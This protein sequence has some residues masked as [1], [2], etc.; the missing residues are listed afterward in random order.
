MSVRN[1]STLDRTVFQP[2]GRIIQE[3]FADGLIGTGTAVVTKTFADS[4]GSKRLLNYTATFT[5]T[6]DSL[7]GCYKFGATV[8]ADITKVI[9][10][11]GVDLHLT[12]NAGFQQTYAD[13]NCA[14]RLS[15]RSTGAPALAGQ[16]I[17]AIS[18]Q[19]QLDESTSAPQHLYPFSF[20]TDASKGQWD[21][22]FRAERDA[23]LALAAHHTDAF[24]HSIPIR[25]GIKNYYI[26][27][28]ET[29]T[30]RS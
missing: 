23:C 26:M 24:S 8:D 3:A 29:I 10:V 5:G 22:L 21:G 25:V 17:S 27:L 28:T 7:Y 16:G 11:M 20:N 2:L 30:N 19:L 6:N 1:L 14:L 13:G 9:Q 4:T 18:F 15:V 12:A